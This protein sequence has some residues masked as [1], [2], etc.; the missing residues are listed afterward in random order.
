VDVTR[1]GTRSF[2]TLAERLALTDRSVDADSGSRPLTLWIE[3][4]ADADAAPTL[5][6]ALAAVP[7]ASLAAYI[8]GG[9]A[10]TVKA[11]HADAALAGPTLALRSLDD[12]RALLDDAPGADVVVA[13]PQRELSGAILDDLAAAAY[14]DSVCASVSVVARPPGTSATDRRGIPPP[15]IDT[16]SWG[17]V[18]IRRDALDLALDN[19]RALRG[20]EHTTASVRELLAGVLSGAGFV[21][22]CVSGT[23]PPAAG[24]R[25]ARAKQASGSI[26]VILDMRHLADPVTGTQ[27][28]ALSLLGALARTGEAQLTALAPAR[29]HPS[30]GALV[31]PLRDRVAF[32]S[33]ASVEKA[34]IFHR[35]HQVVAIHDLVECFAFGSRF[36]LTHQDMIAERTPAYFASPADWEVFRR[37]TS[38]ALASADHVGFFSEH[39]ALDAASDGD[40]DPERATVVPLGVDHIRT[41]GPAEPIAQLSSLGGRPFVLVVGTA[42]QHKNR[43]FALRVLRELVVGRGWE[44]GLVLAGMDAPGG[45]SVPEEQ[46]LLERDPRLRERVLILG[47]VSES[48]KRAL[49]R[50]AALTLFPSLYEGFGLIPFE[51]AAFGT[52]CLYAWRGSLPEFLPRAGA[53]PSDFSVA[54]TASMI[55]GLVENPGARDE[56]VSEIRANAATLSWDDTARGYLEVY[57]RALDRPPRPLDRVV[58]AGVGVGRH[59]IP[60]SAMERAVIQVYRRRP[61]FRRLV[62][63]LVRVG[64]AATRATRL[65]QDWRGDAGAD[66]GGR[67]R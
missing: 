38:A 57:R 33:T 35:P 9:V 61:A 50:D 52:P 45:S 43:L 28:Q 25:R 59:G 49:Y 7:A 18:Y 12:L 29:V 13:E 23:K 26:S 3:A 41:D 44:G 34:D 19:A 6:R 2:P 4:G 27:I 31:E 60:L 56:L 58:L 16:P 42:F 64:S 46:R 40:L 67:P 8:G 30:V 48:Q 55:L 22:R 51:S 36:V 20:A 17:L 65:A 14:A 63:S 62:D 15:A 47:H 24:D 37:T 11:A 39:A 5:A 54:S 10:R 1:P 53:L 32:S 21:H 66:S